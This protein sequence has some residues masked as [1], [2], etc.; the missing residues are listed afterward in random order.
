[1][2]VLSKKRIKQFF[3]TGDS[4]ATAKARG[5][6]LEDLLI[7]ILNRVPGVKFED[8]NIVAAANSEEIDLLFWNNKTSDGFRPLDDILMFECKNWSQP[9]GSDTVA[10]FIRRRRS[11]G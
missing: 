6:A 10:W 8:R 7:Y 4:A 2:P 1:M 9:V 3:S 5:N 11:S